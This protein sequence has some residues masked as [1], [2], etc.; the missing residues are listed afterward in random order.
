MKIL[1]ISPRIPEEGAKGFQ[2]LSFHRLSYLA[3]NHCVTLLCFGDHNKD[4]IA[5][6]KLESIGI[7][8]EFIKWYSVEAILFALASLVPSRSIPFQCAIFKSVRF[9]KAARLIIE[10][11]N[12]DL[13]YGITFRALENV[14][15][16]TGPLYV[17]LVDS[18]AL[19]FFR[20]TVNAKGLMRLGL[21][22]EYK[23]VKLYEEMIAKRASRCFVVSEVDKNE[24]KANGVDVIPLGINTK[25]FFKNSEIFFGSSIIFTGNMNYKPN[26]EAV[27]WF[28]QYCWNRVKL[29]SPDINW[30]IAG[31]HPSSEITHLSLDPRIIIT[32]HVESM[33]ALIRGAIISIA[34]MQSG[35]GMQFKILEAMACGIPVVTT[36]LGLGDI[37]A[38]LG[39][40][41]LV[42]DSPDEFAKKV[43]EL[44]S[45]EELRAKTGNLGWL[46]VQEHH[47]WEKIN[48]SFEKALTL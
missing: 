28:Y 39:K 1:A 35:S 26:I 32:G 12:P 42:A 7:N 2:V 47:T 43:V 38:R 30:I 36:Q 27:L 3:L 4:S 17:D 6:D 37:K 22:L 20:R 23:R 24:I 9:K 48:S 33:G 13:I 18:M 5:K 29:A 10:K 11:I 44:I 41:V 19:N 25:E 16:Y 34:P 21:C 14:S 45:S 8:V 31:N 40:D 15:F 46:Y